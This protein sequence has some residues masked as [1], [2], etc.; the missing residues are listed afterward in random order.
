MYNIYVYNFTR[1][2]G[3]DSRQR[4]RFFFVSL[5]S[6]RH[7]LGPSHSSIQLGTGAVSSGG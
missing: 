6:S 2:L 5:T 1:E 7:D 4:Q 3:F